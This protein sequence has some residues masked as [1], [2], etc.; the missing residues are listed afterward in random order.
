[1]NPFAPAPGRGHLVVLRHA[2][3]E[4]TINARRA[5]AVVLSLGVPI[6]GLLAVVLTDAIRLPTGDS[7]G[8]RAGFVV[9]GVIALTTLSTAFT[10]QAISVGYERFYGALAR[11]GASSLTRTGLVAGKTLATVVL[12]LAQSLVVALVGLGVGWHPH[13]GHLAAALASTLLAT[14]V[15]SGLALTLASVTRPEATTAAA[16]LVYAVLLVGG[17]TMFPAPDLGGAEYLL[18]VTAHADALRA[19]L[20]DGA[21]APLPAWCS[22][23]LW[24]VVA[25]IAAVRAFRWD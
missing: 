4:L 24:S 3:F 6:L 21:A 8:D 20:T 22:L 18:P 7:A 5:E 25:V 11:L 1:M 19:A 12:V 23:G 13:P 2:R 9:P 14:A 15:Y 17:G 16:T 10:G